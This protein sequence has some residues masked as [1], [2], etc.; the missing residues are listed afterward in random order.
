MPIYDYNCPHC[1]ANF[2]TFVKMR[3]SRKRK[4]CPY[5]GQRANKVPSVPNLVT[6]TNF[7][8][9]GIHHVGACDPDNPRD[10]V[11]DRAD[12]KRRLKQKGLRELDKAELANPKMP[13]PK[14]CM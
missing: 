4:K 6:D 1:Y 10:V 14:P 12:W 2:E 9:A 8:V 7:C 13:Q 11:T 5:C 3:D